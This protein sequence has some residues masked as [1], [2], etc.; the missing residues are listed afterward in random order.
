MANLLKKTI[1]FLKQGTRFLGKFKPGYAPFRHIYSTPWPGESENAYSVLQGYLTAHGTP[2]SLTD[3]LNILMTS[4]QLKSSEEIY[5]HGFAWLKD[6]RSM[7]ENAVRRV[8]RK[9][10]LQWIEHNNKVKIRHKNNSIAFAVMGER[11]TNWIIFF[12]FFGLSAD[13]S[14]LKSFYTSLYEQTSCLE[15]AIKKTK[16]P[17]NFEKFLNSLITLFF[18]SGKKP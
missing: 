9:F 11:I 16:D 5:I 12:D 2:V 6:L 10:I 15:N 18:F 13:D 4:G 8:A 17:S 1:S 3:V 14:F 7:N